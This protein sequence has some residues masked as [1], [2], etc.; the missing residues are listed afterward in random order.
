VMDMPLFV[1]A[2]PYGLLWKRATWQGAIA[3]Y[4]S[5]SLIGAILK[6]G[7]MVDVAPVTIISGLVAAVVCPVVS[8]CTQARKS[9]GFPAPVQTVN[10]PEDEMGGGVTRMALSSGS[11]KASLWVLVLGFAAIMTGILMAGGGSK[12]ASTV[13]LSGLAIYFIGGAWRAKCL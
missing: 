7:F 3:G 9:D 10:A 11:S 13:A 2:I 6:F 4:L 5:G 8:L 12:L 1:I